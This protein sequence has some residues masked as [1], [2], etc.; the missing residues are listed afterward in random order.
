M[1]GDPTDMRQR[2]RMTLPARWFSDVAPVLDGLLSGFAL[3]WSSLYDLL[4]NVITQSRVS[5]ATGNF[6]SLAAQDYLSDSFLRR[7]NE[8]DTDY[9][10]RLLVAM[11]RQR[12]TRP[13]V[14]AAAASAGYALSIFEPAQPA[15]TGAYNIPFG[16]AWNVVGA[17]GS[18]QMPLESLLVA[19]PGNISFESEL[20]QTI[21]N[22]APA[23]GA[24]WLRIN[25]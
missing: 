25:S 24:L 14:V 5:T 1:I 17:W 10:S 3:A 23:G 22:A 13:A 9:R 18:M 7:P 4:Q 19:T 15:S 16:L 12:A 11:R 6:L 8:T 20:W 2:L 21:G